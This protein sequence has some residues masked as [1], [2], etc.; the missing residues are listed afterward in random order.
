MFM[1]TCQPPSFEPF[2]EGGAPKQGGRDV[3]DPTEALSQKSALL[4]GLLDSIPDR[5]FFKDCSGVYLGCNPEFAR[6]VGRP[7][8]EIVGRTDYELLSSKDAD[9]HRRTDRSAMEG[10][11]PIRF[12]TWIGYPEGSR[13][14]WETIK[15][16]LR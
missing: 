3:C 7:R 4:T 2:F 9:F 10:G 5:V 8:E 14:L 6:F 13:V 12:E 15:A 16:P 11:G 1:R